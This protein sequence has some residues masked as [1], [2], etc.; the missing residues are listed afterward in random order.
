VWGEEGE[1]AWDMMRWTERESEEQ[2]LGWVSSA[3]LVDDFAERGFAWLVKSS[4]S[5][6]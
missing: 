5:L 4:S 2:R 6:D 3:T 1:L